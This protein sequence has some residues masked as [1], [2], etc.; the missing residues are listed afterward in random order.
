VFS[1]SYA[2]KGLSRYKMRYFAKSKFAPCA[3][4][5]QLKFS[6]AVRAERVCAH[7][8]LRERCLNT[9]QIDKDKRMY[10]VDKFLFK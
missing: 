6:I 7:K 2:N 5:G 8:T 1:F 10:A 9:H 3:P 4:R